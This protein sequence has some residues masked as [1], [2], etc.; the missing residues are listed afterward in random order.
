[1]SREPKCAQRAHL[2]FHEVRAGGEGGAD[3]LDQP[4]DYLDRNELEA[5]L[6]SIDRKSSSRK[7]SYG[8]DLALSVNAMAVVDL[9]SGTS[10]GESPSSRGSTVHFG[11]DVPRV[12][13]PG[14]RH[15]PSSPKESAW[16]MRTE[17]SAR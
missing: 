10:P 9:L 15:S 16:G 7:A 12:H 2:R 4:I 14:D 8:D 13:G 1:M 3:P 6:A 17:P 5:V 11:L